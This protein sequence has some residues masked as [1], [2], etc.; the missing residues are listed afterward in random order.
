M[1][2]GMYTACGI[3]N[4]D[5]DHNKVAAPHWPAPTFAGDVPR[6][7][8]EDL[9]EQDET[10]HNVVRQAPGPPGTRASASMETEAL[11]HT[12]ADEKSTILDHFSVMTLN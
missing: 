4:A 7:M 11:R 1:D 12:N 10:H 3:D 6:P 5:T 2:C 8:H 9:P